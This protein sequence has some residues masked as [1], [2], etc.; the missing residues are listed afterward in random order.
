MS[1]LPQPDSLSPSD[2]QSIAIIWGPGTAEVTALRD[3]IESQLL[4]Q[5]YVVSV[6]RNTNSRVAVA[7][8]SYQ[9]DFERNF[10]DCDYAIA[11]VAEENTT[12]DPPPQAGRG[13]AWLEIGYW[14][15]RRTDHRIVLVFVKEAQS[16]TSRIQVGNPSWAP[17]LFGD[18]GARNLNVS[19]AQVGTGDSDITR[20]A[21][22]CLEEVRSLQERFA[23]A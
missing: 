13:N 14:I 15:S 19:L 8:V 5:N 6:I 2:P 16:A 21:S 3:E 17:K 23:D 4:A 10:G 9:R 11:I 1:A 20:V 18:T 22:R 7:G 12:T